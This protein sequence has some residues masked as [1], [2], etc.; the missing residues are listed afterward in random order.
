MKRH[1]LPSELINPIDPIKICVIGVGGT[2]S[3]LLQGLGRMNQAFKMLGHVG[4][5]VI[6]FDS[7]DISVSNVGRQMFHSSDVG[8]NKATTII[9]KMNRYYGTNW[10]GV[11]IEFDMNWNHFLKKCSF[12]MVCVDNIKA[13]KSII[14]T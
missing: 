12:F 11:P 8:E 6:A 14:P 1:Y 5:E 4:L 7:D 13:R 2:G 3:H 9:T 10:S